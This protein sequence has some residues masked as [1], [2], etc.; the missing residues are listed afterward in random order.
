[1]PASWEAEV[2]GSAANPGMLQS[3]QA[4]AQLVLL[5][6]LSHPALLRKTVPNGFIFM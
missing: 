4:E 6:L 5:L 2:P 1:V 3:I